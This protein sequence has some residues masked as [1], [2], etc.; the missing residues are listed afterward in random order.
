VLTLAHIGLKT[1]TNR[2]QFFSDFF[3]YD[4]QLIPNIKYH[5]LHQQ[6][7]HVT[8]ELWHYTRELYSM[9]SPSIVV[10]RRSTLAHPRTSAVAVLWRGW[11]LKQ[12]TF[13]SITA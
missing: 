1:F 3:K 6:I 11:R 10:H 8:P 4:T 9:N 2:E 5:Q 12:T 7:R 13:H